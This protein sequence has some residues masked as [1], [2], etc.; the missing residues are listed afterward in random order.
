MENKTYYE[1]NGMIFDSWQAAI[2][3]KESLMD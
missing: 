3:Y 1:V 2:E